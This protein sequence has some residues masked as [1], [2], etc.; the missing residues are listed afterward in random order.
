MLHYTGL[1]VTVQEKNSTCFVR[2]AS[3]FQSFQTGFAEYPASYEMGTAV[4]D[5]GVKLTTHYHLVPTIKMSDTVPP[6]RL[7]IHGVQSDRFFT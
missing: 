4:S 7:N 3:L 5:R 1:L 6:L 2:N